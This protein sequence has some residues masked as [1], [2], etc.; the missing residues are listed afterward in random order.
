MTSTLADELAEKGIENAATAERISDLL[1]AAIDQ[2]RGVARGLFPARL[3]EKGLAF[4]L[5]DLVGNASELFKVNCQFVAQNPP[6][7][8]PNNTALHLYYI[9]LEAVANA[10][11]HGAPRNI[12]ITLTTANGRCSLCVQDDGMGFSQDGVAHAGMGLRIMQY[13]ARVIGATL[14]LQSQPGSGTKVICAFIPAS[15]GLSLPAEAPD[16]R[17]AGIQT[18]IISTQH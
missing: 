5:E 9:A 8:L 2:T 11:K 14:N 3:E 15:G 16:K 7:N 18:E 12:S 4:A 6:A 17:R 10:A 1:N 13:R